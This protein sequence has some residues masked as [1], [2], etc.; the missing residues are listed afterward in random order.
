[1]MSGNN[2]NGTK[3]MTFGKSK[4]KMMTPADKNRITFDDVAG[5]D[6]E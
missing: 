4:A 1:M 2:Q 3:S 5:V 6:E